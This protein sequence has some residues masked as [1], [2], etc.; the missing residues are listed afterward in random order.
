M[1]TDVGL[2]TSDGT[3]ISVGLEGSIG[4]R[5]PGGAVRRHGQWGGLVGRNGMSGER[6]QFFPSAD[7]LGPELWIATGWTGTA[8]GWKDMMEGG[9]ATCPHGMDAEAEEE[10]AAEAAAAEPPNTEEEA[11][12]EAAAPEEEDGAGGGGGDG[13]EGATEVEAVD[14]GGGDG[15]DRRRPQPRGGEGGRGGGGRRLSG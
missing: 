3:G 13:D 15:G 4:G 14:R 5:G 10:A 9:H 2:G 11:E 7:K 8:P 6:S 1:Q 12:A